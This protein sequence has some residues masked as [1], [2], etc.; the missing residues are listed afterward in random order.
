MIIPFVSSSVGML[1]NLAFD[2]E[3][4]SMNAWRCSCLDSRALWMKRMV[5]DDNDAHVI[6]CSLR[7]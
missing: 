2:G 7:K 5:D 6:A 4:V 1:Q 3:V